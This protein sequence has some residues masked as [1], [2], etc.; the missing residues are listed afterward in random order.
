M[1][2]LKPHS[3]G[4]TTFCGGKIAQRWQA[5]SE[6]AIRGI[7]LACTSPIDSPRPRRRLAQTAWMLLPLVGAGWSPAAFAQS[8]GDAAQNQWFTGSLI[9]PSPALSKAGVFA[10]EPYAVYTANTGVYDN[11]WVR[12]SAPNDLNQG[13]SVTMLKYGITDELS[14][15]ALP[16]L[17]YQWNDQ[18][19]SRGVGL[20]DLP[21]EFE[22]RF[23]N[24]DIKTGSPS[25]TIDLGMTFPTGAYQRLH[26]PLDGVGTGAYLAKEGLVLESLFDTW[27]D[28]AVRLR[29]FGAAYEPLAN[30]SV[31]DG[32]VY[33]T[34]Q[35]FQGRA[36]PGFSAQ[37]G[38]AVEYGLDQRW[39]L[40][41]DLV[42]NYAD[43]FVLNGTNAAGGAIHTSDGSSTSFAIAPAIEYNW[44]G[45]LGII[46]GVELSIAGRNT[47]SYLAPQV[48]VSMAF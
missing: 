1:T 10:I 35:G 42:Q 5:I 37:G 4:N 46:A 3:S 14:I 26:S 40:A 41:L 17:S 45:N 7:G 22:Y 39:V 27:G 2:H 24:G 21:V 30:V 29:L 20:D 28:H 8:V 18:T 13:Q 43:G 32:S 33:G 36:T 44:S 16:S 6:F 34:D 11:N 23:K 25:A 12:H 19:T 31:H 47:S 9:A 15:E 48:A 38:L